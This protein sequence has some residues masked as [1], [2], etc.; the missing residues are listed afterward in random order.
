MIENL[1]NLV[2][3]SAIIVAGV[4]RINAMSYRTR[5]SVRLSHLALSCGAF[6]EFVAILSHQ[7]SGWLH[8]LLVAGVAGVLTTNRRSP[9]KCMDCGEDIKKRKGVSNATKRALHVG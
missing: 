2:A 4:C 1:F 6:A 7:S 8:A 3:L 9:R 5:Y